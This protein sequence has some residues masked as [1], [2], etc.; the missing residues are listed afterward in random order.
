MIKNSQQL[1]NAGIPADVVSYLSLQNN[2]WVFEVWNCIPGPGTDDFICIYTSCEEAV[3]AVRAYLYGKPT[4]IDE[5][6]VPLHRHPELLLEGIQYA[7]ANAV[8]ISQLAFEGIAER[9][10]ERIER[11]YLYTNRWTNIWEKAFQ[12][13]FLPLTHCSNE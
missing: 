13:Q 7:L 3:K 2:V 8:N 12:Y 4:I 6:V 9:R 11:Y 5:W 10:R 1:I